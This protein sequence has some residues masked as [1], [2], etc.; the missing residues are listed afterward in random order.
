MSLHLMNRLSDV[1]GR[2]PN[3]VSEE[4]EAMNLGYAQAEQQVWR[5]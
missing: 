1:R 3:P 2:H 4:V 5:S